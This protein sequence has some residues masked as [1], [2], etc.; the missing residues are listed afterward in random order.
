MSKPPTFK[1]WKEM[2]GNNSSCESPA[3]KTAEL[4]FADCH[5]HNDG[6]EKTTPERRPSNKCK[7]SPSIYKHPSYRKDQKNATITRRTIPTFPDM[8]ND[9]FIH[10]GCGGYKKIRRTRKKLKKTAKRIKKNLRKTKNN[11]KK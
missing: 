8:M 4:S 2:V 9:K 3:D 5:G 1:Q 7:P 6:S 11:K 10:P